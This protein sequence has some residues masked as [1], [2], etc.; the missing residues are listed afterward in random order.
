MRGEPS[1]FASRERIELLHG[2]FWR[3]E[4]SVCR[5]ER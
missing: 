5:H 3:V 1:M 2:A 4:W